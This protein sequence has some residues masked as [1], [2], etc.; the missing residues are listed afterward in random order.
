M[1]EIALNEDCALRKWCLER[2][3]ETRALSGV[4]HMVV[5]NLAEEYFRWIAHGESQSN[6]Q[7]AEF[8]RLTADE[9]A[10]NE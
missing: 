8:N 9:S 1:S 5:T 10:N 3:F 4:K 7:V 2:A 6:R